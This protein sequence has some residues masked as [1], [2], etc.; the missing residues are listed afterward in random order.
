MRRKLVLSACMM[1]TFMAAVESTIVVTAMPGIATKLGGFS[2]FSWAFSSYMLAQAVSIPVYGRLADAYGRKR[3]FLAGTGLFLLGSVLCGFSTGMVQLVLFRAVQG[4]GAG[5]VQPMANTIIGDIYTPPERARIQGLLSGVFAVS[6]LAGPSL[7]AFLVEHVSWQSVFWVNLPVG[8]AAAAMI[9][10]LLHE[11]VE[12][13]PHKVDCAGAVLL[14]LSAGALT[15]LL[16]QGAGLSRAMAATAGTVSLAAG[17]MLAWHLRRTPEPL[18]PV[19]LWRNRVIVIGSTG[20]GVI[21]AVMMGIAAFLPAYMQAVMGCSVAAAGC[22]IGMMTVVWALSSAAAG[23]ILV[24]T[25]YRLTATIGAILLVLGCLTLAATTP[26]RGIA[27]AAAGVFLAGAGM[28]FCNTTFMVSVQAAVPWRQRGAGTSSAMFLRFMGQAL[29]AAGFGAVLNISLMRHGPG[30]ANA[31]GQLLDPQ[32][33]SLLAPETAAAMAGMVA[34][35]MRGGFL[36]AGFLAVIA[37]VL[38]R[39]LP[40]GLS[41]WGVPPKPLSDKPGNQK[42]A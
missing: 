39:L 7:G 28:G 40:I 20:S 36:S 27:W 22:V 2:L 35:G 30:A 29:G 8:A 42:N 19:E 4:L 15:L 10:G 13:R 32:A 21:G 23:Q 11:R 5:G 1:A 37:L 33:G 41:P 9:V 17:A 24:R 25:T 38:A 18:L 26:A 34:D 6:A 31:L 3:L 12:R 14:A 16:V